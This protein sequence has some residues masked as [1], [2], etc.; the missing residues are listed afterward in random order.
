MYIK[1][2]NKKGVAL[3]MRVHRMVFFCVDI[4]WLQ[5]EALYIVVGAICVWPCF[6]VYIVQY[7]PF[8]VY[9]RELAPGTVSLTGDRAQ[10]DYNKHDSHYIVCMCFCI[11][12]PISITPKVMSSKSNK[13]LPQIF[14][15]WQTK[16]N[17]THLQKRNHSDIAVRILCRW[18]WHIKI[19]SIGSVLEVI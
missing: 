10:G 4:I 5:V 14:E 13:T 17:S 1:R 9:C 2:A 3:N 8:L 6:V 11:R 19:Y 7:N 15:K 16:T 12:A 18:N